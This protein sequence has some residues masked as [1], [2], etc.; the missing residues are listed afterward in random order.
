M[1]TEN[2]FV[3]CL[4]ENDWNTW[5][6]WWWWTE[7]KIMRRLYNAG[8]KLKPSFE[9]SFPFYAC[10]L[11]LYHPWLQ[12]ES[13]PAIILRDRQLAAWGTKTS[14]LHPAGLNYIHQRGQSF[15]FKAFRCISRESQ[16]ALENNIF[17]FFLSLFHVYT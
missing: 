1:H 10:N 15:S 14:I 2:V 3:I 7:D 5:H 11:L 8:L 4:N 12:R 9:K 6:Y 13:Q 16:P 17:S